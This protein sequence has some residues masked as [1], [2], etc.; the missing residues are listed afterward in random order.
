[1]S[2]ANRL[3][4]HYYFDDESHFMDAHVRNKC[5]GELLAIIHEVSTNFGGSSAEIVG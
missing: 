2:D 5:E 1:M 3:Q 4:L